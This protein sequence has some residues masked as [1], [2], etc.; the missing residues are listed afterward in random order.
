MP[1]LMS[2]DRARDIGRLYQA[3]SEQFE[4]TGGAT[5]AARELQ[6]AQWWLTY[7]ITLTQTSNGDGNPTAPPPSSS[8]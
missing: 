7:A 2:P 4:A 6:K 5:Q 1:P 3:L 8:P